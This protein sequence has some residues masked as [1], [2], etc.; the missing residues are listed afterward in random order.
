MLVKGGLCLSS[1]FKYAGELLDEVMLATKTA[2]RSQNQGIP[3]LAHGKSYKCF[4]EE[5][6]ELK[7]CINGA[8]VTHFACWNWFVPILTMIFM[9]ISIF[10]IHMTR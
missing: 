8:E 5:F 10:E 1:R 4:I 2:L 7:V 6:I 3:W 9:K